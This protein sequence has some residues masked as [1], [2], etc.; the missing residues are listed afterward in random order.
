MTEYQF[1]TEPYDHQREIWEASKDAEYYGLFMEMGTGKTK[2]CLDTIGYLSNKGEINAAL[3]L[4]PK[5]VYD[6]WVKKEIPAHMPGH[7]DMVI[8]RW[9]S[10]IT[11]TFERELLK[12]LDPDQRDYTKFAMLIMNIEA[13]STEKGQKVSQLFVRNNPHCLVAVDESTLIKNRQAARTKAVVKLGAMAKYRRILTGSPVTKSPMDLYSQCDF[14]K[15]RALGY[16]SYYSFQSRY[17]LLQRRNFGGRS[18]DQIVGFQNL[19]E[20]T[21]SL[22]SF[23]SRVLKSECLDLPDKVYV[24][25]DVQL[26]PEQK[27][28]YEQMKKLALA[29]LENGELVS[30]SSV[31]TQLMRLQQIVCGSVTDDEGVVHSL[32]NYRVKALLNTLA[33]TQGKVIIWARFRHDIQAIEKAIADEYGDDTVATY[34]GDTPQEKRQQIVDNFQNPDNSLTFFVGQPA[35]GGYGLTLTEAST[36]IYFSN[37]YNLEHR[38]QSEDRAHRIGQ[39][40]SVTYVDLVT[41]G[42]VDE[43]ILKALLT[44]INIASVVLGEETPEWFK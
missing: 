3:I 11:K 19:D 26:H 43:K 8:V 18:F 21:D 12:V 44:K 6:N 25:R 34:Y 23:S 13:L 31:L 41:K 35:S 38:L 40:E 39:T 17:A 30:T 2:V 16:S 15:K 10:N 7:E 29:K 14:L 28:A 37:G 33:E 42:T 9:Q 36:V 24:Q 5:G 27:S 32:K 4:A 22:Q 1:K 20:L